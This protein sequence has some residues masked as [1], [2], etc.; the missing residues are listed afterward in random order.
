M[1]CRKENIGEKWRTFFLDVP[2]DVLKV[3]TTENYKRLSKTLVSHLVFDVFDIVNWI[4][5]ILLLLSK[6]RF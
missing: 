3:D 2:K 6:D 5:L 4:I 1:Y